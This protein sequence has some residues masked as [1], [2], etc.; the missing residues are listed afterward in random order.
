VA[1]VHVFDQGVRRQNL[2]NAG[3]WLPEG[4]VVADPD[5]AFRLR[6]ERIAKPAVEDPGE[7][8]D[9]AKLAELGHGEVA[10]RCRGEVGVGRPIGHA[11]SW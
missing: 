4:R 10:G 1:E 11:L 9:Q 6:L 2:S 5:G 7:A 3:R 8:V